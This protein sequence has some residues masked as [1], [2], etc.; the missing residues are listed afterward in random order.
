MNWKK[1]KEKFPNSE[2]K[3]RE[4]FYKTEIK[5]SRKLINSFLESKGYSIKIGFLNQLN[6]Y[7]KKLNK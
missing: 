1:L 4:Y 2:P 6:D 3:I 7:E 5:D